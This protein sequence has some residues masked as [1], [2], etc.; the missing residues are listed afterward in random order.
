VATN[1]LDSGCLA[2]PAVVGNALIIRTNTHL[3]RI[4]AGK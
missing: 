4:E 2:S 1:A 3:Y